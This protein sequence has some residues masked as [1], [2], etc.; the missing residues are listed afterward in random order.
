[1]PR[2]AAKWIAVTIRQDHNASPTV[3]NTVPTRPIDPKHLTVWLPKDRSMVSNILE[4]YF[5]RLN[6]HRPV[7]TRGAFEQGLEALYKGTAT[8]DPGFVCSVYLIFALGTLSELNH[9]VNH[10]V[11]DGHSIVSGASAMKKVMPA[12]WP[13]QEEFF[14][15]A[16][17]VKPELRVT[18]TSLQAL[19]LLHWYLYT[20]V[21]NSFLSH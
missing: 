19:I 17:A 12:D 21:S 4:V 10:M 6:V 1:M 16:L 20:E 18:I 14:E 13:S 3:A 8:H 11:Q 5:T 2:D 15:L 9:R 7:Y